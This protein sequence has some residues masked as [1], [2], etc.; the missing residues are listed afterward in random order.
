M[1]NQVVF[2]EIIVGMFVKKVFSFISCLYR[3]WNIIASS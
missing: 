1:F 2:F 3:D